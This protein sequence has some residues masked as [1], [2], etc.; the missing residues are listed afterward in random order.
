MA[1]DR[2]GVPS[3]DIGQV[4]LA[5]VPIG[6]VEDAS[7]RLREL[8]ADADVLAAEDTRRL[9]GLCD[10]L[11]VTPRGR[12]VSYFAGNESRRTPELVDS[13]RSG[14]TVVL[15]TDA[16]M[17]SISDPGF[18]LVTECVEAEVP[19]RAVPGPSAVTAA[20]AVSGLPADRFCFEGFLP[21]RAGQRRRRLS[22]LREE[23]RTMVFFEAPHRVA[24]CLAD[25]VEVLGADRPAAMC[26]ELTKTF[27]EVRRASLARLAEQASDG[28]RGEITLVVAGAP[29][30][31]ADA[32]GEAE[33][34]ADVAAGEATGLTRKEAIAATARRLGVPKREVYAAVVAAAKID[35]RG[36]Q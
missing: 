3:A 15:V 6:N 7:P 5:G 12:V 9:R 32:I 14:A 13:A 17:P 34:V 26:R 23:R 31:P 16:G 21:R 29:E 2:G 1:A 4:V 24:D 19:V 25:M 8:L 33:L 27:E 35:G 36:R 20:L 28:V 18:R 11:G 10:R 30:P 22:S